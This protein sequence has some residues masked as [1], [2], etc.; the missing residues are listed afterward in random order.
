MKKLKILLLEDLVADAE[1]IIK[2]LKKNGFN[3]ESVL[4]DNRNDYITALHEFKPDIV[5]SDYGLPQYD[6][7]SAIKDL[8][9]IYPEIPF[10]I[11]TG[12]LDEETAA[13]TIKQGAWDYVVKERLFRLSSAI[14]QALK[15][16]NEYV[17]KYSAEKALKETESEIESL[18]NNIPVGLFRSTLD[19]DVILTNKAFYEMFRIDP[20]NKNL[21]LNVKSLY[22]HPEQRLKLVSAIQKKKVIKNYEIELNR[23]DGTSFWASFY[24]RGIFDKNDKLIY[25]DGIISDVTEVKKSRE[26]LIKA[27][28]KA[29]ESDRLK[30]AFLANMSHE[31]RTPMNAI[32]GFSSLLLDPG[33]SHED[34]HDFV[35]RIQKSSDDLLNI[36][37]DILDVAKI[38]SGAFTIE[39]KAVNVDNLMQKV[40]STFDIASM[41]EDI[42]FNLISKK[43]TKELIIYSDEHRLTQVLNNLISNAFKFT[44]S[45]SIN[46]GYNVEGDTVEFF[47]SDTGIG[48]PED[49]QDIIFDMFRQVDESHTRLYGGTGLGLTIVHNL[50]DKMGGNVWVESELNKG[51]T[52]KFYLPLDLAEGIAKVPD[53]YLQKPKRKIIDFKGKSILIC[54]DDDSNYEYL[55]TLLDSTNATVIRAEDGKSSI[56]TFKNDQD[57]N[58]ILMDIQMPGINGYE[59][60]NEIRKFNKDIPI[61]IQT[62]YAMQSDIRKFEEVDCN[63]Y[64]IKP[65]SKKIFLDTIEKY[66]L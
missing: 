1:L 4:V 64:L 59:A 43:T 11:V 35:N 37:T 48:I 2:D 63:D 18:R 53:K 28:E 55:E 29:E 58:L 22:K 45:G 65:I 21:K 42:K 51:T 12:S 24:I 16:K 25:Q 33:Y 7:I 47:V 3:F 20:E 41:H 15:L 60:I 32:I 50:I 49:K 61:I 56:H 66:I 6:G 30:T 5:L 39:H 17:Q 52:F 27:K 9:D 44:Q 38:E 40:Y 57:I 36:I 10:I 34:L 46:F 19:G 13:D 62:A 8:Q 31:I 54:E 26:E 23:Q 14:N